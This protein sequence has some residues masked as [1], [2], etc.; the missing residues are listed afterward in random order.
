M[1][2]RLQIPPAWSRPRWNRVAGARTSAA[3]ASW[4][5]TRLARQGDRRPAT[6]CARPGRG[7]RQ[8]E[9]AL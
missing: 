4:P 7:L 5:S 6:D 3:A 8:P 1:G 9:R 2:G